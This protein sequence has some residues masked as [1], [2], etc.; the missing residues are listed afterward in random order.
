MVKNRVNL[1]YNNWKA[2]KKSSKK[3]GI[4]NSIYS[5]L[6][7][8]MN[9]P[10][11]GSKAVSQEVQSAPQSRERAQYDCLH[12]HQNEAEDQI[13]DQSHHLPLHLHEYKEEKRTLDEEQLNPM[14][15]LLK[16]DQGSARLR[17]E[18]PLHFFDLFCQDLK[19]SS[20]QPEYGV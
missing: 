15:D 12:Y 6:K 13:V 7:R 1:F 14:S 2:K 11:K 5:Y 9:K 8:R 18:Q 19:K 3:K 16:M 20:R 4:F 17:L 10:Q